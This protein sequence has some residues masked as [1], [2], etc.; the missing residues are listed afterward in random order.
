[1]IPA[2]KA[3]RF[4]GRGLSRGLTPWQNRQMRCAATTPAFEQ[5]GQWLVMSVPILPAHAQGSHFPFPAHPPTFSTSPSCW[6][7]LRQQGTKGDFV[8]LNGRPAE[9]HPA[10]P[11][12][13]HTLDSCN[14]TGDQAVHHPV[15]YVH[16]VVPACSGFK[17][18]FSCQP[19]WL[20]R[21]LSSADSSQRDPGWGIALHRDTGEKTLSTRHRVGRCCIFSC[22][23]GKTHM[24]DVLDLFW[25]S[26]CVTPSGT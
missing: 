19:R 5:T 23:H 2:D 26:C 12:T 3:L 18:A 22:V 24:L 13:N 25:Q 8:A 7:V 9:N 14:L 17:P 21:A 10:L 16:L 15:R 1:V 20:G 4:V 11:E 6:T